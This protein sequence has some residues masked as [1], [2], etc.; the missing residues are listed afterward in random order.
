M[1]SIKAVFLVALITFALGILLAFYLYGTQYQLVSSGD[2]AY[3]VN[4]MTGDVWL[5]A[6]GGQRKV[7]KGQT[8]CFNRFI[9]G[10]KKRD[11]PGTTPT[12]TSRDE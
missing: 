5:L 4:R 12:I 11:K 1:G 6:T 10:K 8:L 7:G 3:K 9:V 2:K